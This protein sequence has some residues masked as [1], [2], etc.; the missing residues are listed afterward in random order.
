LAPR[1][2]R[3]AG[4]RLHVRFSPLLGGGLGLRAYRSHDADTPSPANLAAYDALGAEVPLGRLA[5]RVEGRDYVTAFR[6]LD[7]RAATSLRNDGAIVLGLAY[8]IR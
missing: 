6:G 8:H 7:G 3:R 4:R 5:L 2:C 1:G